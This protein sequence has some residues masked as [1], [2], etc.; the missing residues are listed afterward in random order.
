MEIQSVYSLYD[1]INQAL[2]HL[3]SILKFDVTNHTYNCNQSRSVYSNSVGKHPRS[4]HDVS[5]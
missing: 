3:V 2:E 5:L 4:V 1:E